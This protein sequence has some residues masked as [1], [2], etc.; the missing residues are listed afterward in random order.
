MT[1]PPAAARLRPYETEAIVLR[2]IAFGETSQVVHL[3]TPEHG[4]VAA[5]AKGAC[6][7]GP[8]FRGGLALGTV[9]AAALSPRRGAEL[10]LLRSFRLED[11]LRGL[12]RGLDRFYAGCYILDLLRA[13][14]RPALPNPD[15]YRAG[16]AA[17]RSVAEARSTSLAA[18]VVWFEARAIAA[19]GHGPRLTG[20]AA[21]GRTEAD[22]TAF[23][24]GAGGVVHPECAPP[25]PRLRLDAAGRGALMRI[26]GASV[27]E[28]A[29]EPLSP[30]AV[31][32]IRQVHDILV[33]HLL[34]RRPDSLANVPRP[35]T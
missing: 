3:A 12:A 7:P 20:C 6:R 27:A 34:E 9:G 31:G 5:L 16:R 4:L 13:W 18:W 17:L 26:Y 33:P 14:M 25:G 19:G 32:R 30:S 10:E 2:T 11:R 28:L 29:A 23:S 22:G 15:L 21:C 1:P 8:D 24:P 35:G